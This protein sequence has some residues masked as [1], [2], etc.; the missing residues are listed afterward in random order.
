MKLLTLTLG[1][2]LT[3]AVVFGQ[4]HSQQIKLTNKTQ[5][6]MSQNSTNSDPVYTATDLKFL[7]R[8]L[9]L[10]E[11]ALDAG[12][13][14]FGS[15]LVNADNEIIAEA[16]NRIN[17]KNVLAHPEIELAVWAMENLSLEE[18]REA[19]MY[20][21]GEHCPMCAGAHGWA[22]IGSLYFLHSAEQ[23]GTWLSDMGV[24]PAPIEF[25][26]AKDIMKNAVIKGPGQGEMLKK[27]KE[28]HQR[29][30]QD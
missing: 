23:L 5:T 3:S 15:I 21:T 1:L 6:M 30:Y 28:L 26:P 19:I 20:T 22:E 24:G 18:R 27:I 25:V 9:M 29:Y 2:I 4:S 10:A 17:E 8:C 7:Q 13:Q 14:P 16:R 12:D 11:E